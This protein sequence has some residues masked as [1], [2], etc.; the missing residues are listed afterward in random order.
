MYLS[1]LCADYPGLLWHITLG[2]NHAKLY[3]NEYSSQ[4]H[5]L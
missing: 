5:D 4:K 2:I 3:T 1:Q